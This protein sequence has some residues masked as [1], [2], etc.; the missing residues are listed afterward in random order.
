MHT[1]GI[2]MCGRYELHTLLPILVKHFELE[3]N[4]WNMAQR[5]N[6]APSQDVPVIRQQDGRRTISPM[7]WGL[8]PAWAKEPKIG[9]TMT[10]ARCETAAEKPAFRAAMK[11]R[12]CLIPADGFYEWKREGKAKQPYLFR[13]ADE[14]P[15]AFA[16]LWEGWDKGTGPIESCTILTT[17]PNGLMAKI[18]DRMPVILSPNDYNAWLNPDER[19]PKQLAFLFEPFPVDELVAYPV[20]SVVNSTRNEVPQC[21]EPVG[22]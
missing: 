9:Y 1:N 4:L 17:S 14:R 7:R 12:R 21:I 2:P 19:N 11:Y 18:H 15:M 10:N 5:Y 6:I 3:G 20:N 8:I 22:M 16:G 13:R